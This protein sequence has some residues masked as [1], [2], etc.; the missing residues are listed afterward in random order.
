MQRQRVVNFVKT[1]PG[2]LLNYANDENLMKASRLQRWHCSVN[3]NFIERS[4][5][6]K[7]K[8]IAPNINDFLWFF[9]LLAY[10]YEHGTFLH[11]RRASLDITMIRCT[12]GV[13]HLSTLACFGNCVELSLL[14][15]YH[16]FVK[17]DQLDVSWKD[18]C[19]CYDESFAKYQDLWYSPKICYIRRFRL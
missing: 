15:K 18:L 6:K 16:V 13:A 17:Y 11:M 3:L 19:Q 12:N 5:K 14:R 8:E 10:E 7:E 9:L 2:I 4:D 1:V